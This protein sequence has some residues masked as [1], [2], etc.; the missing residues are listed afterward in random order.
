MSTAAAGRDEIVSKAQIPMESK[1]AS[2]PASSGNGPKKITPQDVA[3]LR[4][5]PSPATRSRFAGK[6]GL[7]YDEFISGGARQFAD[8]ILYFLARDVEAIVRQALT[9]SIAESPNLPADLAVDLAADIIDIARPILRRSP[10]LQDQQLV[11]IIGKTATDH[12]LVVASRAQIGE[13]LSDAL[14]ASCDASVVMRLIGNKGAQISANSLCEIAETY[15]GDARIQD[16][17]AQRPNLPAELVDHLLGAIGD[18]LAWDLVT[19]K[20]ISPDEAR[21]LVAATKE[22]TARKLNKNEKA[23]KTMQRSLLER[24]IDG[25]LTAMD[26]LGFLRDGD[27]SQFELA[28]STMA[29]IGAAKTRHLLYNMDKRCLAALCLRAG[30]GTPQYLA[31][32]MAFDLAERGVSETRAERFKYPSETIRFVQDQYDRLRADKT[33]IRQMLQQ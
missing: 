22:R 23:E 11:E 18:K 10:V 5:N 17:L 13:N 2:D 33:L 16:G 14:I 31:I 12:A 3:E 28:L 24:M 26:V 32:R 20:S 27:I 19:E 6:F 29:K 8:G 25:D 21:R 4:S 1:A 15:R 30:L 9:E 7:Q